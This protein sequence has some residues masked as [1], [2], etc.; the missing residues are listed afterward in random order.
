MTPNSFFS[1]LL[2]LFLFLSGGCSQSEKDAL[3]WPEITREAKPWSRWWWHGSS[4]TRE[5]ITAELEAYRQAGIGGLELTPIYG[6][7]GEEDQFIEYLSPEW[8]D[9]LEHTLREAERLGLGI[10]IATGTGWPF[11]GPWVGQD[12]ACKYL[13]HKSYQL[14]GGERL[15][16]RIEFMQEPL[17]RRVANPVVEVYDEAKENPAAYLAKAE[18]P[19]DWVQMNAG[20]LVEPVS[21]NDNLQALAID[22]VRFEKSLPL[23]TLMAF[24]NQGEVLDLTDQVSETGQLDW[25]GPAGNW[26]LYALFEGRHGK[27][28]ERAAP[29][30]EGNVIDHFS[31]TAIQNYLT[32]FDSAFAKRNIGYLRSFFN[33]SY[34]VDDAY[35]Q[36]NWTPRFFEEYQNRRGYDLRRHLPALFGANEDEKSNRVLSDYR[37]TI[38]ELLLETFTRE[39]GEW[40]ATKDAL[41]RNQAHGAPANILDL[42]AA[43]DIPETEGTDIIRIK[44]ATSAAHVAGRKLASAEA[45]TWLNEHFLSTLSDLKANLDR[46][47]LGGVNHIFYHGTAYSPPEEPWPGR[48][49]YAAVHANSRNS[50]W[51]HFPALNDYVARTQAILQ[52]GTP[53]NDILLYFPIYDRFA[54]PGRELLEHFD[55]EGAGL[56]GA[57]FKEKADFLQEK[58]YAFDFVSDRQIERLGQNLETGGIRY[59][60][61]L[62]PE[63]RFMPL[64]TFEKLM[65]L[66]ESGA[67]VIFEKSL[68]AAVPGLGNLDD[69]QRRMQGLKD[70]IQFTGAGEGIQKAVVGEGGV[71]AGENLGTVLKHAGI[72]RETLVDRGLAYTRRNDE[73]GKYYFISNWSGAA[74]EGW[75]PLQTAT[76]D[77]ALFD[78]MSGKKGLARWRTSGNGGSEVYLQ[79]PHGSS[80]ILKTCSLKMEGAP[81]NYWEPAGEAMVLEGTW[82]LQAL[83][84]G[85]ELPEPANT[86]ALGSWTE[87]EG[88]AYRNFSGNVRYSLTFPK[89]EQEGPAWLLDLG[90]VRESASVRLNGRELGTLIG[91]VFQLFIPRDILLEKNILEVEVANLMA[92]RI[93][94]LD[95]KNIFWKKFYNI[96]FSPRLRENRGRHGLFDASGWTPRPSGLIGPATIRPVKSRWEESEN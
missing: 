61:L 44:F 51:R 24:S 53:D 2:I 84:G 41:V 48:L 47:F 18:L 78:P 69:R 17:L 95:R 60:T 19:A 3:E 46:Y 54:T 20:D 36:A 45:A 57:P 23:L 63:C 30:G 38:S 73:E 86:P 75:I 28:V 15:S 77:I 7:I 6:V 96:N 72:Q 90:E 93:A 16:E 10:D 76:E 21:A 9:M 87:L 4:V 83:E 92:N 42:Y 37:Q 64:S 29:G 91:P 27:M 11:G 14:Q 58:G 66:A 59:R 50:L 40:A 43:S 85:P 79:L 52:S 71:L 74:V 81:W 22:Q 89:P 8:M 26:T 55:G 67:T 25:T 80:V 5:G 33:D 56:E 65:Q 94:Y 70:Q 35:G 82:R 12:D 34:E 1:P 13:T 68:P 62:V 32:R 88:E 31:T 49:F 39:W